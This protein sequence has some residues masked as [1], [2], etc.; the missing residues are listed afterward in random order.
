MH[1]MVVRFAMP[2]GTDWETLRRV[3]RERAEAYYRNLPGL[4][5]KAFIISPERREY[6]GQYVWETREQLEEFL[7]SEIFAGRWRSSASR[8]S[9][10]SRCR[11]TSSSPRRWGPGGSCRTR[12]T[13]S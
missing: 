10:R 6:G 8:R 11:P 2:E 7:R 5:S 4:R 1:A 12:F 13:D 3:A 9:S